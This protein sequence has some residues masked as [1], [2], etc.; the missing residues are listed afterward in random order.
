MTIKDFLFNN[1]SVSAIAI[2]SGLASTPQELY[3]TCITIA[4]PSDARNMMTDKITQAIIGWHE[5]LSW[6][7]EQDGAVLLS[8]LY[9]SEG[10]SG[11]WDNRRNSL[12]I[13]E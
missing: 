4:Y 3:D 9:E 10:T 2:P 12:T 8:R 5:L 7:A 13:S 11:K 6:Y 1:K